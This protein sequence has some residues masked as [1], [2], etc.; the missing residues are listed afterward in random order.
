MID[1][2]RYFL[3]YIWKSS[4]AYC[5]LTVL[6]I[7]A[8]TAEP[9]VYILL[10]KM[11]IDIISS[12]KTFDEAVST[13]F[14]MLGLSVFLMI[15][16]NFLNASSTKEY[17]GLCFKISSDLGAKTMSLSYQDI[18]DPSILDLFNKVKSTLNMNGFLEAFSSI[19]SSTLTIMGLIFIISRLHW[20]VFLLV[21]AV[22]GVNVLCDSITKKCDYKWAE[23]SSPYQRRFEYI[24]QI[25]YG[26][27]YGKEIRIN[28]LG[29]YINNKFKNSVAQYRNRLNTVIDKYRMLNIARTVLGGVQNFVFYAYLVNDAIGGNITLG[30]FTMFAA[31]LTSLSGNLTSIAR[32]V[33]DV[34]QQARFIDDFKKFMNM[35]EKKRAEKYHIDNLVK[36]ED[37]YVFSF[38]DVTFRYPNSDIDI[39]KNISIDIKKGEK[40]SVVGINGA[41]KTTFIKLL[42]R[43]YKP[44]KGIITLN[45]IDIEEIRHDEYARFFGVVFQDFQLFAFSIAENI[46]LSRALDKEKLLGVL[47]ECGLLETVNMLPNKE[48]TD[49]FKVFSPSGIELS[50]GESQKLAIARALYKD[51]PCILL[52]EPLSALDPLLEYDIY[53]KFEKMLAGKTAIYISHRMSSA[54]L[55]D[56]IAVFKDGEIVQRGT[57][58]SLVQINGL[59]KEMYSKQLD[60][61]NESKALIS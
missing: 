8:T 1:N 14:M 13:L 57:H 35:E 46:I 61:Y 48:E 44:T 38:K 17:N 30:E 45:S 3:K 40:L 36:D 50:G 11:L 39:L 55:C 9:F 49:V 21:M 33:V 37:G 51:A 20:L 19:I 12:G 25:M 10:P 15:S 41:G 16:H 26:F 5:F 23:E 31:A 47:E 22:V 54:R 56:A 52:D 27:Q 7:A 34:S 6:G 42:L 58:D 2:L 60:L 28:G 59:Y 32:A 43:L 24:T 29:S 4:K 18:E 53:L